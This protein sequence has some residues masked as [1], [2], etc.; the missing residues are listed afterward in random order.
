MPKVRWYAS[1]TEN[2][3]SALT[4]PHCIKRDVFLPFNN[5]QFGGQDYHMKQPKKTLA[6]AKA[7]QQWAEKAQPPMPGEP[8]QL[9]ECMWELRGKYG[10]SDD[11]HRYQHFW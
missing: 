11:I 3:Y 2:N 1:N 9:V 7:L 5:I 4:T 10:A 8:C 6:Y